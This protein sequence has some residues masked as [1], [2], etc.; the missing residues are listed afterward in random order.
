[1]RT[2]RLCGPRRDV[3]VYAIYL[4]TANAN[5]L[6]KEPEMTCFVVGVNIQLPH[7]SIWVESREAPSITEIATR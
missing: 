6:A 7:L 4:C 5:E 3:S 2:Q 1:M